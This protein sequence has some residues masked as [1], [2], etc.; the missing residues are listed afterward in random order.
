MTPERRQALIA[1]YRDGL[2]QDTLPFW[3]KN[4]VD[5]EFGG[6]ITSLDQDGSILQTDKSVWFQGRF[7]WLL[8]DSLQ[9]R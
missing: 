5:H 7:A 8:A 9:H 6:Y 4:A 3:I 2:L 1:T